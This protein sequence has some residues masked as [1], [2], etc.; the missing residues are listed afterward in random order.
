MGHE[1]E[2]PVGVFSDLHV[3]HGTVKATLMHDPSVEGLD[4]AIYMDGSGSMG[5]EYT[6][7][8]PEPKKEEHHDDDDDDHDDDKTEDKPHQKLGFFARLFGWFKPEEDHHDEK[9]EDHHEG[10]LRVKSA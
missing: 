9:K 2:R 10:V 1:H 5:E 4:M 8:L 7:K 6:Y 3:E